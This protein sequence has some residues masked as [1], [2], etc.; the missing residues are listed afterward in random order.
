MVVYYA[1]L[2]NGWRLND[3]LSDTPIDIDGWAPENFD[4][5]YSGAVTLADAFAQ[6]R[7]VPAVNLAMQVGIDEVVRTAEQLGLDA[8]LTAAPSLALGTS[9]VSLLDMVGVFASIRA[10]RMPLQ[11]TGIT[12]MV[13][14]ENGK[15]FRPLNETEKQ[16]PLAAH[17][18]AIEL[19]RLTV[20]QGTGKRASLK[21]RFVGGKTGT[22]QD[23]RDAW[24][25]GFVDDMV[26]GVW[27]GNDDNS[28]MKGVTGGSLPAKIWKQFAKETEP[29]VNEQNR[30]EELIAEAD[31]FTYETTNVAMCDVSAC[32]AAYRSFR[33][34]DCTY[35]PY[36]GPRTFCTRGDFREQSPKTTVR[37]TEY[38]AATAYTSRLAEAAYGDRQIMVRTVSPRYRIHTVNRAA[39]IRSVSRRPG[40]QSNRGPQRFHNQR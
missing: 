36:S 7:N 37:V 26:I 31:P 21:A 35:Q 22:S 20:E 24:F 2:R 18:E 33:A 23:Y 28:P 17:R 8:E 16:R 32:Q 30:G 25:I 3:V 9:E 10:G 38:G 15:T 14:N 6:S 40:T 4:H 11:P 1:A 39:D 19:L 29:N 12:S 13:L 27:V 34:S 5:G